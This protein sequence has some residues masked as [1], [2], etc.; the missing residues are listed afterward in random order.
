MGKILKKM[1]TIV[2]SP[3]KKAVLRC[4]FDF[5]D[6]IDKMAKQEGSVSNHNRVQAAST[7]QRNKYQMQDVSEYLSS[8]LTRDDVFDLPLNASFSHAFLMKVS[9]YISTTSQYSADHM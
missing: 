9:Q 8:F 7:W 4:Q 6:E 2:M 3:D 5:W 1:L